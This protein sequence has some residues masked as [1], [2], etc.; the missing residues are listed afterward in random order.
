MVGRKSGVRIQSSVLSSAGMCQ[1]NTPALLRGTGTI[2]DSAETNTIEV[3]RSLSSAGR[4]LSG[5]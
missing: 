5:I 4:I 3:F 2:A 1:A